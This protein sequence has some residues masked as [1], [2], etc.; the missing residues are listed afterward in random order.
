MVFRRVRRLEGAATPVW[1]GV[2]EKNGLYP[3]SD[4]H[5]LLLMLKYPDLP[6]LPLM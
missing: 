5:C 4:G 3:A 6:T 1:R 2:L